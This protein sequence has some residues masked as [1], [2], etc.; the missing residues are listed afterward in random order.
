MF[1]EGYCKNI[2]RDF[3]YKFFQSHLDL[4]IFIL[5]IKI[6]IYQ[7]KKF[8]QILFKRKKP[9]W[10]KQLKS[11]WKILSIQRINNVYITDI[12]Q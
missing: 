9:E 1:V 4:V 2:K 5:M 8:Q 11:E 6:V 10:I 7:Q 3:L 12:K